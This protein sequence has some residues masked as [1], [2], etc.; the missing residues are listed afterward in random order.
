MSCKSISF[1]QCL[2]ALAEEPQFD[3]LLIAARANDMPAC[4]RALKKL[5]SSIINIQLESCARHT[6]LMITCDISISL[7]SVVSTLLATGAD[8]ALHAGPISAITLAM[9][10]YPYSFSF[11]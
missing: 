8:P 1:A 10:R 6:L 7:D 5:P 11:I 4:I 2:A 3:G 9:Q